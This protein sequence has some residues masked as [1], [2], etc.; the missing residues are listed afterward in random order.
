MALIAIVY[1]LR[2]NNYINY[3]YSTYIGDDQALGSSNSEQASTSL[4]LFQSCVQ[5]STLMQLPSVSRSQRTPLVLICSD[6]SSI[7]LT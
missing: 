6:S 3:L 5:I 1:Y 4:G 2:L 7:A